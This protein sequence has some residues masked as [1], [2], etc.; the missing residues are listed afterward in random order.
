MLQEVDAAPTTQASEAVPK[1]HEI[2]S[3]VIENW[4][5]FESEELGKIGGQ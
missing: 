4:K 2:T 5:E 3:T 1:L